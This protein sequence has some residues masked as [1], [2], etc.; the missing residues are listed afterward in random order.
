VVA[1]A[2]SAPKGGGL[3]PDELVAGLHVAAAFLRAWMC[4]GAPAWGWRRGDRQ[5]MRG[6][7]ESQ[8]GLMGTGAV[9]LDLGPS[10]PRFACVEVG[11]GS[12][13]QLLAM[14]ERHGLWVRLLAAVCWGGGPGRR[15][16]CFGSVPER[17]VEH[18]ELFPKLRFV[19]AGGVG[20]GWLAS[21]AR[22][23]ELVGLRPLWLPY[24]GAAALGRGVVTGFFGC[25]GSNEDGG[26]RLSFGEVSSQ[27]SINL[28]GR[29]GG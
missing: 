2:P 6:G 29:G 10:V 7:A 9:S 24:A 5:C 22:L 28:L 21:C 13:W 26:G 18:G 11:W 16:C 12:G 20:P 27:V 19:V 4:R 3:E 25:V 17:S 8:R 14:E 15:C 23:W 1:A